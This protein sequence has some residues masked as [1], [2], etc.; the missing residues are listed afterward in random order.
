MVRKAPFISDTYPLGL[1]LKCTVDYLEAHPHDDYIGEILQCYH[2]LFGLNT[3]IDHEFAISDH[4]GE[5]IEQPSQA[6]ATAV[7]EAVRSYLTGKMKQRSFRGISIDARECLSQIADM[8][9]SSVWENSN[10]NNNTEIPLKI[11]REVKKERQPRI[12]VPTSALQSG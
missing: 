1:F 5:T 6:D 2:C 4:L 11:R 9:G 10:L 3:K 12:N 8:L 7:F